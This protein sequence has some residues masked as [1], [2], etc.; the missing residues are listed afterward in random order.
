M[1]PKEFRAVLTVLGQRSVMVAY[2]PGKP[3]CLEVRTVPAF[4]G[5]QKD[6]SR[7]RKSALLER[8]AIVYFGSARSI[9]LDRTGR[10]L[11]PPELRERL[12]LTERIAFV[13]IDGERFQLWRP[14]DLDDVYAF[15]DEQSDAIQD[16]LSEA[17]AELDHR[18]D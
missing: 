9:D 16:A 7:A 2:K 1:V 18:A 4:Q 15:C 13:G 8:F 12:G 14:E 5:F 10:L 17:F 6:F 11:L 3:G